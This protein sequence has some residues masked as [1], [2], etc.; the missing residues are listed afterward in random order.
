MDNFILLLRFATRNLSRQK[1]RTAMTLGSIMF[2]VVGLILSGGFIEDIFVQLREVT[3]HSRLG[4]LQ[5]SAQGYRE[6]WTRD[7]GKYLLEE[8]RS[9]EVMARLDTIPQVAD[10]MQRLNFFGVINNGRNELPIL[11]EG[12]DAAREAAHFGRFFYVIEGRTLEASDSHRILV[13]EGV[14]EALRLHPGALVTV[15]TH[16][17]GGGLNSLEFEVVGIFRTFSREFDAHAVRLPL[18]DAHTLLGTPGTHSVVVALQD[19]VLTDVAAQR[20]REALMGTGLEIRTWFELDDFYRNTVRLYRSEFKV[21]QLIIL[22]VVLLSVAN[23]INM[24][25]HERLGEFGTLRAMGLKEGDVTQLI[26]LEN[27]VLGLVGSLS[28]AGLGMLLAVLISLIGIPMP[29]PPN[30]SMGYTAEIR[31]VPGTIAVAMVVGLLA[32][33]VS[34]YLA[35]RSVRH[36]SLVDS[37]RENV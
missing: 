34:A 6:H 13:G 14:A 8:A 5:I 2:G 32:T 37:L 25:A 31:L 12:I 7:P 17:P 36:H 33:L 24:T 20:I 1:A 18:A 23:S 28:G 10:S 35:A 4:H 29:P 3:I 15:L 11:G 21:L 30:S 27:A 19:T 26:L 22:L 9:A 16:M